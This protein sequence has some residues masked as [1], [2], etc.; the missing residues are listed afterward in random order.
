[1][2]KSPPIT[3]PPKRLN[4]LLAHVQHVFN[5]SS[6]IESSS[7]VSLKTP[8][9]ITTRKLESYHH[10]L[11]ESGCQSAKSSPLPHRRLDKLEG[12]IRDQPSTPNI[13]S[14]RRTFETDVNPSDSSPA[15][16]RRCSNSNT[17]SIAADHR[18]IN[19]HQES[20]MP[21][22]RKQH[23]KQHQQLQ[24]ANDHHLCN[25]H[26]CRLRFDCDG[27]SNAIYNY[28][29]ESNGCSAVYSGCMDSSTM[30][31]SNCICS[32][33]LHRKRTS[34]SPTKSV[35]G[36]PGCFSSPIHRTTDQ[37]PNFSHLFGS[38]A[39]SMVCEPGIFASPVRSVRSRTNDDE[40]NNDVN[41][42]MRHQQPDQ[43]IVSGWLKFRDNKRVSKKY[44]LFL[45]FSVF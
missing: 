22:R 38:P 36:E 18:L 17:V 31:K 25:T 37:T 23:Q 2:S 5:S 7:G 26:D 44:F 27:Y 40:G 15:F 35:I 28:R 13:S 4:N 41:E 1:M 45:S 12:T 14:M 10:A 30:V 16:I 24:Q 19:N 33:K 21:Y 8:I 39:K 34:I 32:P 3:T 42:E 20:P 9:N 29:T 6:T 11:L 43:S